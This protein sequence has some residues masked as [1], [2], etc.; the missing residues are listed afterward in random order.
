MSDPTDE[1]LA[2][3]FEGFML[4]LGVRIGTFPPT[5]APAH[6][7]DQEDPPVSDEPIDL[8]G[9]DSDGDVDDDA[10]KEPTPKPEAP[11]EEGPGAV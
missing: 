6:N 4:G 9:P 10:S 8:G 1:E 3:H 5:L 11:A 7:P 2:A